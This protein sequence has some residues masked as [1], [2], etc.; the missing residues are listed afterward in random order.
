MR[1]MKNILDEINDNRLKQVNAQKARVGYRELEKQLNFSRTVNSLKKNLS[2]AGSSGIIAEFKRQSPSR[3]IINGR[4]APADVTAGYAKAGASGLSVLTEM[5]YFGGSL[6]DL[7]AARKA[8]PTTPLLRKDFMVDPYQVLE[9]QIEG[10]DVILLIAASLSGKTISVLTTLAHDLGLE[11]LLELHDERELEKIDSRVDMVGINNR[12]LKD[13]SVDIERSVRLFEQLPADMVR[14]A[15]SG[16]SDPATV[17][18]LHR[19]G[20]LGFLMGE[21]FMKTDDPAVTCADFIQQLD[22]KN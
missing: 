8:N 17:N 7:R 9:A 20:F 3:G 12:N 21:N 16:I 1:T 5:D 14:I 19:V 11:V 2:S 13:F 6:D 15:E 22:Y 4:V 18:Y 10:A